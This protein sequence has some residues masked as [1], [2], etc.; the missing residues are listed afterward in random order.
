MDASLADGTR[1]I[2]DS[3]PFD[4]GSAAATNDLTTGGDARIDPG[5]TDG[6]EHGTGDALGHTGGDNEISA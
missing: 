3:D 1:A 6:A 5:F 2:H 4:M